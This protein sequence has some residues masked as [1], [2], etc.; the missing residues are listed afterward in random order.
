MKMKN[1]EKNIQDLLYK[2]RKNAQIKW[3]KYEQI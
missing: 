3:H 1:E 2:N